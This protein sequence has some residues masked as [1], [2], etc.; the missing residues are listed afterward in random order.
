MNQGLKYESRLSSEIEINVQVIILSEEGSTQETAWDQLRGGIQKLT[1]V[2]TH[3]KV[4][5]TSNLA[6]NMGNRGP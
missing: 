1:A 5:R 3:T 2:S 4:T 6:R